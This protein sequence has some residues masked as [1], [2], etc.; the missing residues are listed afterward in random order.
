[1]SK[2]YRAVHLAVLPRTVLRTAACGRAIGP[3]G[4]PWPLRCCVP[5]MSCFDRALS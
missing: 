1:M 2:D 3:L 5:R 4:G